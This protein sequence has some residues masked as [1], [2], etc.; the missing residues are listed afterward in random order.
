[1]STGC[2]SQP[3]FRI[4]NPWLQQLKFDPQC[5]YIK[6]WIRELKELSPN[7]IHNLNNSFPNE[8]N[9]P[10]QVV[11]HTLHAKETIEIFRTV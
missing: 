9:Y 4:F 11:N 10:K 6:K 8:L 5:K 7:Q 2:D 1:M 3:Y